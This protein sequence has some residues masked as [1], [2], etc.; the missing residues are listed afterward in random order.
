MSD[1]PATLTPDM[2]RLV[3]ALGL[4]FLLTASMLGG[5]VRTVLLALASFRLLRLLALPA[6]GAGFLLL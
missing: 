5:L 3:F 1:L 6:I 4:L 2:A